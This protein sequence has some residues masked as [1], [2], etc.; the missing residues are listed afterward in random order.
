MLRTILPLAVAA[1]LASA[2]D[3]FVLGPSLP[4]VCHHG[5]E[6]NAEHP[7]L[8]NAELGALVADRL[9]AA[10]RLTI[11]EKHCVGSRWEPLQPTWP[12]DR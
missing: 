10:V 1:L 3:A 12:L 9:P 7:A 8:M 4:K 2:A 11:H 6:R 5:R